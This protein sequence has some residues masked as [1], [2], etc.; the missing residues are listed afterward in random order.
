MTT[1]DTALAPIELERRSLTGEVLDKVTLDPAIFSVA[2]NVPLVH[3]VVT[4]Y[5]AGIRAG[6]QS[7]K[8]RSEVSGGGAKP[9]RQKGTGNAR[10]GTIS[11]PHYTGGGIALGPKPR[12]Y[13]QKTPR[14]MIQQALRCVLSDHARNGSLRL[15]E[16]FD[17][18]VPRTKTAIALLEAVDANGK[19]LVVVGREDN[20]AKRSFA[21]LPRV[22]TA[23]A[24]QLTTYD[25]LNADVVVF[26]DHTLPGSKEA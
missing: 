7:T 4:A 24:D 8:T 16:S 13:E 17:F 25:V 15:V 18:E 9:Y 1:T 5:L 3:Q 19:V 2:V 22:I 20:N 23:H 10:Q 6:T 12:S 11:A 14:K 26:A 21:N